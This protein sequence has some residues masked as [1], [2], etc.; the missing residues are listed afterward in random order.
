VHHADVDDCVQE[1][2]C[3]VVERLADFQRPPHR[4]GLRAW[5]YTLVRSKAADL[6]RNKTRRPARRLEPA[7]TPAREPRTCESDPAEAL[8]AKWERAL[9]QSVLQQLR[10]EVSE[11]NYRV[12]H[13]RL[14]ED[15]DVKQVAAEL[16][17][18]PDQVRYRHHR[19]KRKL[20]TRLA[21]FTGEGQP[22]ERP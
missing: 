4:P 6:F 22:P 13:M 2:W 17:L 20:Q 14:I 19:M 21:V 9:L 8:E 11:L 15:Q 12:L 7:D 3:E 5:L 1:V 10:R 18:S 16:N